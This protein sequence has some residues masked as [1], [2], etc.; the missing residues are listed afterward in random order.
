MR[1]APDLVH[2]IVGPDATAIA[3]ALRDLIAH[4]AVARRE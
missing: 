3:D 2:V 1:I 4:H